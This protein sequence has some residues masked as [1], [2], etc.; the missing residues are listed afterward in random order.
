MRIWSNRMPC[1]DS[2]WAASRRS[3]LRF[4]LP[5]ASSGV[6]YRVPDRVF[7][8]QTTN[9]CR[10]TATMSISP[11][12]AP[13]VPVQDAEPAALQVADRGLFAFPAEHVFRAHRHHL[14][15]RRWRAAANKRNSEFPAVGNPYN[16]RQNV[17]NACHL[18]V[19]CRWHLF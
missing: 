8:S 17:N 12:A 13:P 18:T 2:H 6:P 11:S 9:V 10:S 3:R 1:A 19:K 16:R 14:R 15:L 4:A 5:T 7:T